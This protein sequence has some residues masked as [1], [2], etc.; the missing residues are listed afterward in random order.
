M[1]KH[2]GLNVVDGKMMHEG[3]AVSWLRLPLTLACLI[4]SSETSTTHRA[5][6]CTTVAGKTA[7]SA[8]HSQWFSELLSLFS[9]RGCS[10]LPGIC[11]LFKLFSTYI[12]LSALTSLPTVAKK[13]QDMQRGLHEN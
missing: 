11:M 4:F 13:F 10:L 9:V 5:V 1:G 7:A 6:T 12:P 8:R 3:E 2:F